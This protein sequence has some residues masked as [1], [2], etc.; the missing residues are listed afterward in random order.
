MHP[1]MHV[2]VKAARNASKIIMRSFDRLNR[3]KIMEKGFNDFVSEADQLAEQEIIN[4]IHDLYPKHAILGE[5]SGESGGS[6]DNEYTWIIDPI[7]GT[8]NYIHGYPHFSI[9]IAV[10]YRNK[11]QCGVIY[12]LIAQEMYTAEQGGGAFCNNKRI[13]VS[14]YKQ[15][16]GSILGNG[17]AHNDV[18]RFEEYMQTLSKLELIAAGIRRS[19]S[20]ALDFAYVASGKLDGMFVFNLKPWDVAAGSLLVTEA[21]GMI[22]DFQGADKYFETGNVVAGN[23]QVYKELLAAIQQ[24]SA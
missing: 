12:D 8:V 4:T 18:R 2:A 19:G 1:L 23:P 14:Q 20:S 17:F 24:V 13:R 6:S 22:S 5:E 16:Q 10:Q 15:L 21:G 9:S 3:L 11:T 7:D